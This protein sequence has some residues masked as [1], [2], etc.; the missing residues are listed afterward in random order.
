MPSTGPRWPGRRRA[1]S[2]SANYLHGSEVIPLVRRRWG[3]SAGRGSA[4]ARVRGRS[5]WSAWAGDLGRGAFHRRRLLAGV[6]LVPAGVAAGERR[7]GQAVG[8]DGEP[9]GEVDREH[10]E[11]LVREL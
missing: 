2:P 3:R 1:R 10:D 7:G 8:E 4:R 9:D 11:M 5:E 6:L